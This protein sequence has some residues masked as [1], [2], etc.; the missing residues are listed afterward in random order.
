MPELPEVET[1]RRSLEPALYEGDVTRVEASGLPLRQRAIEHGPMQRA[2]IGARFVA[3]RRHG[4]YLMLDAS[5]GHTLLVHLGM[6]GQL[7]LVGVDEVA[8]KHTH[9]DI[10]L[11]SGRA[12]RFVDPRRFGSVRLYATD[13]VARSAELS[14]L[15]PDPIAGRFEEAMLA[16]V[17][18]ATRRDVKSVLL[19]QRVVAGLGNIYVSEALFEARVSPRRRG[20]RLSAAE[21]GALFDAIGVV[22]RRGVA[23]RGTSFSDYVDAS[24]Q[25]GSNQHALLV[26]GREAEPCR[27][28]ATAVRRIVQAGRST[29]FCPTCQR[30]AR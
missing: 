25:S 8:R 19:D 7:L 18:R 15:G 22:L 23:N 6:A 3:A 11:S 4:K 30:S 24:G 13:A 29:F 14:A 28:C 16:D 26:Y 5:S 1:V 2:L 20:H 17:L 27:V 9:V 12:L 10:T 21:R